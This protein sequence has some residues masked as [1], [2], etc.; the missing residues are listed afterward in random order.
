MNVDDEIKRAVKLKCYVC[1]DYG[2]G[3]VC[4]GERQTKKG[5]RTKCTRKFHFKCAYDHECEMSW[6]IFDMLC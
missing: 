1:K 4:I 2:A 6:I 3:L 5:K